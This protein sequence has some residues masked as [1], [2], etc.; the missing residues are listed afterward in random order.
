MR[1]SHAVRNQA[2]IMVRSRV[3]P[4]TFRDRWKIQL[5]TMPKPMNKAPIPSAAT[6]ERGRAGKFSLRAIVLGN[7]S[8]GITTNIRAN[9]P[10]P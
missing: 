3:V 7:P 9:V 8:R 6:S 5:A 1:G 10:I 4:R 2:K